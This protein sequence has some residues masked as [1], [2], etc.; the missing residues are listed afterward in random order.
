MGMKCFLPFS[1]WISVMEIGSL[2]T[3]CRTF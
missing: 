2:E 1:G 3:V